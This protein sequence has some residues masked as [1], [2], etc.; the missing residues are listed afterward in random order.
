MHTSALTLREAAHEQSAFSRASP[1]RLS[2]HSR[3]MAHLERQLGLA[4]VALRV[5]HQARSFLNQ[6][7]PSSPSSLNRLPL[8]GA[9]TTWHPLSRLRLCCA[10]GPVPQRQRSC[11]YDNAAWFAKGLTMS[12]PL[13]TY[14]CE[15]DWTTSLL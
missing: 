9:L 4:R 13:R 1:S 10:G 14:A 15:T 7:R 11:P 2:V 3:L 6:Y 8:D 5:L 12:Q